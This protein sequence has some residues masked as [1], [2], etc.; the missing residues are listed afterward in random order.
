M[1]KC[2]RILRTLQGSEAPLYPSLKDGLRS[3]VAHRPHC[4]EEL[5]CV[6]LMAIRVNIAVWRRIAYDCT[7]QGNN[8]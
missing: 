4:K 7:G 3:A 1:L 8:S 6:Y 2:F 5:A